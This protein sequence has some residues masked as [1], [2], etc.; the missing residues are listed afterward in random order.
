MI[1]P[2][3]P[4]SSALIRRVKSRSPIS[5]MPPIGTVVADTAA[6]NLLTTWIQGNSEE[7]RQIAARCAAS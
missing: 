4:E 2:G 1:D 5:Q 6:V 3:R 7:W